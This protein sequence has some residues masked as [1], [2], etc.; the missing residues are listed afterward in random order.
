[1]I[2]LHQKFDFHEAVEVCKRMEP[3][4]PYCRRTVASTARSATGK[5]DSAGLQIAQTL[6]DRK[7]SPGRALRFGRTAAAQDL[8]A[9]V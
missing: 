3:Y 2:D 5:P 8:R 4:R 6:Q 1:M 7:P 9:V